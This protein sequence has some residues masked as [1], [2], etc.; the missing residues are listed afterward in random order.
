MGESEVLLH[1]TGIAYRSSTDNVNDS[2]TMESAVESAMNLLNGR[3]FKVGLV[4]QW[5][6]VS[7]STC[8]IPVPQ[9]YESMENV[10]PTFIATVVGVAVMPPNLLKKLRKSPKN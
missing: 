4:N 2:L 7:L 10:S 6:L 3:F 5:R 9:K 1:A 8:I